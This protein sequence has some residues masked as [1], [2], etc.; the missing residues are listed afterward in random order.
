MGGEVLAKLAF[1][2]LKEGQHY[3]E[4]AEIYRD[5]MR[6]FDLTQIKLAAKLGKSQSAVANKIRLLCLCTAAKNIFLKSATLTERHARA[7]VRIHNTDLQLKT[8]D[9]I[10]KN[11]L[12]VKEA[13]ELVEK[14]LEKEPKWDLASSINKIIDT[15]KNG[16]VD[17]KAQQI[18]KD[19]CTVMI[20]RLPK[21]VAN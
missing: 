8:L 1:E 21:N 4:Q 14:A 3:L 20:I 19:N 17:I 7:L 18:E 9:K 12:S 2:D 6:D 5:L 13:E 10:C 16:G 15:A 11:K